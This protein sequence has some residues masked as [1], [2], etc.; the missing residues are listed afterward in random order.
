[1]ERGGKEE[2]EEKGRRESR[3]EEANVRRRKG[4]ERDDSE[5]NRE[6][7]FIE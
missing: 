4:E 2:G 6:T 1:M 5:P 3:G 7:I